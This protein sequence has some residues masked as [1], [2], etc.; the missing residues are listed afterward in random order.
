MA[1][2]QKRSILHLM[3]QILLTIG[4]IIVGVAG[5]QHYKSREPKIKRKPKLPQAMMVETMTL[6]P[7]DYPGMIQAMGTVV[8]DRQISLKSKV[9]GEVVFLSPLFVRGGVVKKGD[10]LLKIDDTDYKIDVQKAE[11][12]LGKVMS[13]FDIEQGNQMI[14]KEEFKLIKE[15]DI[16][17]MT[18]T[19]LALRKPQLAQAKAAIQNARADLERARLNLS[20]TKMVV[21]FNSIVFEKKVDQGSMVSTLESVATLVSVDAYHIETLVPPDRLESISMGEAKGSLAMVTSQYSSQVWEGQVY[22][23]TGK[24]S[25]DSRMAGVLVVVKDPLGLNKAT[26]MPPLMLDDHVS[27]QISGRTLENVIKLPRKLL[28]DENTVW[29]NRSGHLDIKKVTLAWKQDQHVYISHGLSSDDNIIT[30][31]LAAPV[32]GMAL[33]TRSDKDQA[34]WDKDQ[35]QL[36]KQ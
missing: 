4:F 5:F 18:A 26:Q 7:A 19:D 36:E 8:P 3:I 25:R 11:S 20:R 23:T 21:P 35:T 6:A 9:T 34:R 17:E 15:A 16:G 32:P 29:I 10:I 14:A 24:I 22:R 27:V 30:T 33:Q 28:R 2:V 12:T 13:D 31:D 1:I